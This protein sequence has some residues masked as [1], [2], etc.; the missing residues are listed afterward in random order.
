MLV[1]DNLARR[2]PRLA[3]V[4]GFVTLEH[5]LIA[6]EKIMLVQRD[7]GD[8]TNRKHARL[9]YTIEVRNDPLFSSSQTTSLFARGSL[10]HDN[11]VCFFP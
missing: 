10:L 7:H 4:L 8:R 1:F 2:Y 3:D 6:G 5:A 9:K 11:N